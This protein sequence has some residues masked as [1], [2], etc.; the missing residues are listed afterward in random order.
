M[1]AFPSFFFICLFFLGPLHHFPKTPFFDMQLPTSEY[2]STLGPFNEITCN[3]CIFVLFQ[4]R[5]R[6]PSKNHQAFKRATT[7]FFHWWNKLD[8]ASATLQAESQLSLSWCLDRA[9]EK[10]SQLFSWAK[11]GKQTSFWVLYERRRKN[12]EPNPATLRRQIRTRSTCCK[13][14][15]DFSDQ[16][17][18]TSS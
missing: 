13:P 8:K 2:L 5:M 17:R 18:S 1:V 4:G 3:L 9:D 15:P 14:K 11:A 16:K 6:W 10:T 12:R 7:D